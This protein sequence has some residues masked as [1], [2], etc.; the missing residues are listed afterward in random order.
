MSLGCLGGAGQSDLLGGAWCSDP[1]LLPRCANAWMPDDR[2]LSKCAI[3]DSDFGHSKRS[4]DSRC[5]LLNWHEPANLARD[6]DDQLVARERLTKK[7]FN[8]T[9][10]AIVAMR[11]DAP[12]TRAGCDVWELDADKFVRMACIHKSLEKKAG[13]CVT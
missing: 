11:H 9:R 1:T 12:L 4:S 8:P 2:E 10:V 13:S 7:G 3:C 5:C 6:A